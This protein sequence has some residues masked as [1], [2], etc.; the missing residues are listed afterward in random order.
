[1]R[2]R[3][4]NIKSLHNVWLTQRKLLSNSVIQCNIN[5]HIM[6][7]ILNYKFIKTATKNLNFWRLVEQIVQTVSVYLSRF[8]DFYLHRTTEATK[9]K[10]NRAAISD[11]FHYWLFYPLVNEWKITKKSL[12]KFPKLTYWPKIQKIFSFNATKICKKS[13]SHTFLVFLLFK[14]T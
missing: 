10:T 1:M 6:I 5:A 11:Y 14:I 4:T 9:E 13:H 12:N 7:H 2:R 3:F 8:W